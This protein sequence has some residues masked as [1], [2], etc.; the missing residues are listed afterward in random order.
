MN[1]KDLVQQVLNREVGNILSSISPSFK[2]FSPMVVNYLMSF[3]TPYIEAFSSPDEGR[4][5]T[6]A[7]TAFAKEEINKKVDDFLKKFESERS[8]N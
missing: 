7:A 4:I 6:K 3:L 5:N 8:E 1:D 2:M